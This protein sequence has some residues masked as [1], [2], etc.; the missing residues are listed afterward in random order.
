METQYS[1]KRLLALRKLTRAIA[2]LLRSQL[3]DYLGA[4]A[5]ALRPR[6]MLGDYVGGSARDL[7]KAPEKVLQE[8]Q[9]ICQAAAGA[10]PFNLTAELTLLNGGV[11]SAVRLN[12]GAPAAA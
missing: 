2:E 12:G 8:L 7:F 5:P 6:T 9:R 10:P 4:L 11:S 3:R 1:T